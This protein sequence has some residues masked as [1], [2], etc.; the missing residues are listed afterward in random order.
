MQSH[1]LLEGPQWKVYRLHLWRKSRAQQYPGLLSICCCSPIIPGQHID[2]SCWR[3]NCRY[4]KTNK[5]EVATYCKCLIHCSSCWWWIP[6]PLSEMQI[7]SWQHSSLFFDVPSDSHRPQSRECIV[8]Y[9]PTALPQF[10]VQT[11]HLH[12]LV[13]NKSIIFSIYS[14][15][16]TRTNRLRR[17]LTKKIR[18]DISKT[19]IWHIHQQ[20]ILYALLFYSW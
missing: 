10:G 1:I 8:A 9:K 15:E 2:H 14:L 13:F 3:S 17:G 18:F 20:P 7:F 6:A 5:A 19:I 16:P 11:S 12:C 4:T